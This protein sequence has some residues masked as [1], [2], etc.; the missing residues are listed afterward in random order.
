MKIGLFDSGLGGLILTRAIARAL[1]QYD[2]VYLGDT[3]RVPYGNRSPET[4]YEFTRQGVDFLFRKK[5]R[6]IIVA[7]NT[8]SAEALRKIQR[9]HLPHNYPDRRVLG[10]IIPTVE[11]VARSGARSVG[12]LATLGTV[13]SRVYP[14]ELKKISPRTKVYQEAAP[15]LVPLIES[16]GRQWAKPIL[17]SY[18]KPLLKKRIQTL[19]LGC[20]HYPLYK[21]KIRRWLPKNI[22]VVSQDEIVPG[23]LRDYLKRHP[24]MEHRLSKKSRREFYV[25]DRTAAMK[26]LAQKWFGKRIHLKLVQLADTSFT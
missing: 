5:C 21:T 13:N 18:L 25:T 22:R 12:V 8:A 19:L 17:Q 26:Q 23:K 20:T 2:Y 10:V 9:T 16:G 3:Q 24:E 4:I 15:L 14:K 6:L 7:C 1:P 11:E